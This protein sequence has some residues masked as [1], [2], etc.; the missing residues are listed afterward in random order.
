MNAT[1]Q[2]QALQFKQLE[3]DQLFHP[4]ILCLPVQ[5][6][7]CHMALH[8]AKYAGKLTIA[9]Q[10]QNRELLL[11][12]LNDV[13]IICLSTSNMFNKNIS[14]FEGLNK[15]NSNLSINDIGQKLTATDNISK[16]DVFTFSTEMITIEAGKM[17]KAIESLDHLE[18]FP[19]RE[20][21]LSSLAVIVETVL[22]SLSF[23]NVDIIDTV[24]SRLDFVERKSIFYSYYRTNGQ[25]IKTGLISS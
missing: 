14:E 23:M 6:R 15:I 20:E 19:Y 16:E 25:S 9:K 18:N 7:A 8:F 22:I 17:A 4:D 12:T 11:E 1:Q 5:R 21:L 10:E 24:L 2:L 13:F 3:H